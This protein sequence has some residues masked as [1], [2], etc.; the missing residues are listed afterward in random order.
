MKNYFCIPDD[1]VTKLLQRFLTQNYFDAKEISVTKLLSY[2]IHKITSYSVH[3]YHYNNFVPQI[4]RKQNYFS[5]PAVPV[6]KICLYSRS[7]WQKISLDSTCSS[8]KI[9][10]IDHIFLSRFLSLKSFVLNIFLSQNY[11]YSSCYRHKIT[12]VFLLLRWQNNFHTSLMSAERISSVVNRFKNT[13]AF[14]FSYKNSPVF[15]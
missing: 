4:F 15:L 5:A 3:F 13:F 14:Y 8:H 6:T 2:S 9:T 1:T 11:F 10:L 12:S 7:S